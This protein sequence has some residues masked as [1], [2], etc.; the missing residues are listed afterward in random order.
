MKID[1]ILSLADAYQLELPTMPVLPPQPQG[2]ALAGWIDHTILKPE[3]T[4]AQI[5][6]L[7]AEAQ[8]HHFATVCVNPAYVLLSARLLA[9]SGVGVCSVV[10]FPL[11]ATFP[12]TKA[13][14]TR[15][16]IDAGATEIDTVI[17][18]GAL[19]SGDFALAFDDVAAVVDAARGKAHVKVI[20][21]MCY[22][23]QRQKIAG[24]LLCKEAGAD[25][26]KTSTG[27]GAGGATVEDVTLMRRIVGGQVGVKAAGGIRTF[28]DAM[29]MINAGANRLGAS[30]GISI[31]QESISGV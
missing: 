21:E 5:H 17:N 25:F 14:E 26:V 6:K 22:L 2:L 20:L 4:A 18:F 9:G 27:F 8:E 19:R 31:L 12:E 7:C 11:G 28:K 16:A 10:G 3:T 23:D 1:E 30:A 24:C 29:A 13:E 15:R